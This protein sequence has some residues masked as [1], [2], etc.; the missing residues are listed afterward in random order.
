MCGGKQSGASGLTR[1]KLRGGGG[2]RRL[3]CVTCV[4]E[5]NRTEFST[6]VTKYRA[7]TRSAATAP[8]GLWSNYDESRFNDTDSSAQLVPPAV[9]QSRKACARCRQACGKA[10]TARHRDGGMS[11]RRAGL[12][13]PRKPAGGRDGRGSPLGP[14]R[15]RRSAAASRARAGQSTARMQ[16]A[17]LPR[18]RPE[19]AQPR[20][21][22]VTQ[23]PSAPPS[24]SVPALRCRPPRRVSLSDDKGKAG[25]SQT[26]P[27][28]PHRP[29]PRSPHQRSGQ[30][31]Q[32]PQVNSLT[33][34]IQSGTKLSP[35]AWERGEKTDIGEED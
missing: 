5:Q 28:L 17:A 32:N 3:V 33:K 19:R 1:A 4:Y 16:P 23:A 31:G 25:C 6:W 10:G 7:L 34:S 12:A 24:S 29:W 30:P 8:C 2:G 27:A 13:A 20:F 26:A 15:R 21:S 14:R 9:A 35:C 11:G 22:T 18:P